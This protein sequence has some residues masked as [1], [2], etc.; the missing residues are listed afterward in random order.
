MFC[1]SFLKL[2]IDRLKAT[3]FLYFLNQDDSWS[4]FVGQWSIS[5]IWTFHFNVGDYR[6]RSSPPRKSNSADFKTQFICWELTSTQ[7]VSMGVCGLKHSVVE[8]ESSNI[9]HMFIGNSLDPRAHK[10]VQQLQH[11][12]FHSCPCDVAH[13]WWLKFTLVATGQFAAKKKE[14]T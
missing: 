14:L 7:P 2:E 3:N 9:A 8:S 10:N 13:Q 12:E 1:L 4:D 11:R 6:N 5:H